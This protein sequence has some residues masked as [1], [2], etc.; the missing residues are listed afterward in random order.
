MTL[1]AHVFWK[2]RT[3]QNVVRQI[4][5]KYRFR[6]PL[7][8]QHVQRAQKHL[9]SER[10]HV[11]HIDWSLWRQLSLKK[12]LLVIWKI[13]KLF[14]NTFTAYDKYSV[15]NRGYLTHLIH[16]KLLKKQRIFSNVFLHFWNLHWIFNIIEKKPDTHS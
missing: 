10:R 8:N 9:K 6:I 4:S 7:D 2:W 16:M 11:Y 3:S 15:L 14:V 5:K 12:S 13:L 1:I